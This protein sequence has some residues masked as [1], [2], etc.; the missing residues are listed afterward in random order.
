[1]HHDLT[2]NQ[3]PITDFHNSTRSDRTP[4]VKRY[5]VIRRPIR[6]S[7]REKGLDTSFIKKKR[8]Q[9]VYDKF[10]YK[11]RFA[12]AFPVSRDGNRSKI[13]TTRYTHIFDRISD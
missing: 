8:Y 1:M 7:P 4:I 9:F 2:F 12:I 11:H 13:F 5:F 10:E 6:I 3:F